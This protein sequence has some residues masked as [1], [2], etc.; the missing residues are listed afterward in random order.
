MQRSQEDHDH[1]QAENKWKRVNKIITEDN[2]KN[3]VL[4]QG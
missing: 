1:N 3:K 2:Y 4:S